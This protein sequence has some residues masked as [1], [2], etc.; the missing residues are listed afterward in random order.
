[1][2]GLTS[3]WP[4]WL[5]LGGKLPNPKTNFERVESDV[6]ETM[7]DTWEGFKFQL[8]KPLHSS[9]SIEHTF[10]LGSTAEP[11]HYHYSF[12]FQKS[13]EPGDQREVHFANVQVTKDGRVGARVQYGFS[14]NWTFRVVP[15][16]SSDPHSSGVIL[17]SDRKGSDWNATAKW[18]LPGSV[19]LTYLQSITK[20]WRLGT[21]FFFAKKQG[22]SGTFFALDRND[23]AS[24]FTTITDPSLSTMKF[25]TCRKIEA[26]PGAGK[27]KLQLASSLEIQYVPMNQRYEYNSWV[28]LIWRFMRGSGTFSMG[29]DIHGKVSVLL[30]EPISEA[31]RLQI[32]AD[33]DHKKQQYKVGLGFQ[34]QT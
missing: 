28:G 30:Q 20:F 9:L 17:E 22:I 15:Q 19:E 24:Q 10:S 29:V 34:M 26:I 4:Q 31:A 21:A 1:M 8:I 27:D 7:P 2:S 32:C 3:L 16:F 14:P 25:M 13:P 6:K 23:G 11:P 33:L 18:I 5:T 12:T